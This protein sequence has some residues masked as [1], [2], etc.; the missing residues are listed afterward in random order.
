MQDTGHG[1]VA[2]VHERLGTP[3]EVTH[4]RAQFAILTPA[5]DD[6]FETEQ[7]LGDVAMR[8]ARLRGI[9]RL[10]SAQVQQR[11][12]GHCPRR[13]DLRLMAFQGLCLRVER[14]ELAAQLRRQR[15]G[16]GVGGAVSQ[17]TRQRQAHALGTEVDS[18]RQVAAV[19]RQALAAGDSPQIESAGCCI[20]RVCSTHMQQTVRG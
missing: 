5:K 2:A 7:G 14:V 18:Q 8:R 17:G 15:Y 9:K 6:G 16:A 11:G 20:V 13:I 3:Q 4:L 19:K 10:Q 1:Q 12:A